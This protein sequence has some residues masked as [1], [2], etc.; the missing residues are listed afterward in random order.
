MVRTAFVLVVVAVLAAMAWMVGGHDGAVAPPET[1]PSETAPGVPALAAPLASEASAADPDRTES[2][3]PDAAGAAPRTI[4]ADA[5][6]LDVLVVDKQTQQPVAGADAVWDDYSDLEWLQRLSPR[7]AHEF[8]RDRERSAR[9]RGWRGRSDRNGL[10][11]VHLGKGSTTVWVREGTRYGMGGFSPQTTAPPSG[12]RIELVEDRTLRVL[13]RDAAGLPAPGVP[14]SVEPQDPEAKDQRIIVGTEIT[15][16]ADGIATFLHVQERQ[17]WSY[18]KLQGKPV[19]TWNV[20]VALP[21]IGLPPIAVDAQVLPAEPIEV[22]L[23]PTGR[24][25][26]HLTFEGRPVCWLE[27]LSYHA[28]PA[29]DAMAAN[30][31]GWT[32]IDDD[33]QARFPH[34][35]LG[36]TLFLMSRHGGLGNWRVEVAGPVRPAEEV[37]VAF[38]LATTVSSLV[39]RVFGEDGQPLANANLGADLDFGFMSGGSLVKTDAAGRFVWLLRQT[40]QAGAREMKLSR[41]RLHLRRD[42][43]PTLSVDVAPRE[44]VEGRNDLGDLR[45]G[46]AT[47]VVGGRFAFDSPGSAHAWLEVQRHTESR[48]RSGPEQRWDTVRN[49]Q[50]DVQ[51]DGV[52]AVRGA[53][54]P[55]RY[56]VFVTSTQH[57]PVEPVEFRPGTADLVIPVR[58]GS[59]L[60]A[61]CLLPDGIQLQQI[62]MRLAATDPAPTAAEPSQGRRG[63][64]LRAREGGHADGVA[65][66]RW[67]AV[68]PGAYTLRVEALGLAA[69]FTTIPD[70]VVPPPAGGDPRLLRIDLRERVGVLRVLVE[71]PTERGG[72]VFF[73]PPHDDGPRR[74]FRLAGKETLLP[75]PKGPADLLVVAADFRPQR[76]VGASGSVTVRFE[77]WPRVDLRFVGAE[78]PADVTLRVSGSPLD[79]VPGADRQFVADWGGGSMS[80]FLLPRSSQVVADSAATLPVTDGVTRLQVR[81]AFGERGR[82]VSLNDVTPNEIVAGTAVTM[83]LS[84]EEITAAVATMRQQT[85]E[86]K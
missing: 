75:A 33:G 49:L 51:D 39:G 56:R 23:P 7:E 82:S 38:D 8:Y 68:P 17:I 77:P 6:W 73:E 22:Q 11:R 46:V 45:L 80:Q 72:L 41:L 86:K 35:P 27:R 31:A 3:E 19:A 52:F 24:L 30:R 14:V 57:L 53:V 12:Y 25:R 40:P 42:A 15:T 79:P 78:V 59:A 84:P 16:E 10:L 70:V 83:T 20:H 74:G 32:W 48:G 18:G 47:L 2:A 26:A 4:P 69:P 9:E 64:R 21:G 76:I 63:D 61:T 29:S 60:E 65:R 58:R 55:G 37:V 67:D 44:L 81:V 62:E 36:K 71:N 50:L 43:R 5:V 85:N 28:G 54:E 34:V 13:V 66:Y 1:R